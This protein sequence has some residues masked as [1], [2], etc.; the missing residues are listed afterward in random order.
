M[1]EKIKNMMKKLGSSKL[2]I[3]SSSE[4]Y[5]HS[6][7][8]GSIQWRATAGGVSTAFDSLMQANG[9]TWIALG[10]GNAD[11]DASEPNGKLK[12]PPEKEAYTLKRVFVS[13]KEEDGF[14]AV[15]NRALWPLS[16]IAYVRPVFNF[17][18]WEQY[19]IVNQKMAK[20]IA[21]EADEK[22][23]VLI[24]D[25]HLSLCAKYLK[26]IKPEIKTGFFWHI[27][28]PA[29]EMF[30]IFPWEKEILEGILENRLIGFHVQT[31]VK[32]FLQT[33][34]NALPVQLDEKTGKVNYQDKVSIAKAL[35]IG[36]DSAHIS[37]FSSRLTEKE[38]IEA[39]EEYH[40]TDKKLL[41]GVDRMD[42]T[43]GITEKIKALDTLFTRKPE[44]V[45]KV[46]LVQ[47][48]APS[49]ENLKEYALALEE[50]VEA[51][52]AV[53]RKY[54]AG[55]WR[56][57]IFKNTFVPLSKIIP[58]YKAADAC[59]ITSLSDGMNLVSKEFVASNNGN[60]ML[61]LSKFA[62]SAE[63]MTEAIQVSPF[64][65]EDIANGIEQA[66]DMSEQ[67]KKDRMGAMKKKILEH[68]LFEWATQ[69]IGLVAKNQ[70]SIGKKGD[71]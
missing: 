9:G 68:D 52:N 49:R 59:I 20:S 38:T 16:H 11:K 3:A 42:Y 61:V 40:V 21:E 57:I 30:K 51:A 4:P 33:I 12:V 65:V 64:L 35:P 14:M 2:L 1:N 5:I 28:W 46:T 45:G 13:K 63:E 8:Q 17:D 31:Y 15:S 37:D 70:E 39:R 44:L 48:A 23:I 26:E 34:K 6:Y 56:P 10:L 67:E 53:N 54:V 29:P 7:Y 71:S 25:Y 47:I 50:T 69:F 60:G 36:V 32:N 62:G 41:V 66:L 18:A 58:L 19:K 22:T 27:P 24:N 43:K 55:D